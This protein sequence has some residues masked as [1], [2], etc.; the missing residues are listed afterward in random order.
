MFLKMKYIKT[1]ESFISESNKFE[2]FVANDNTYLKS[3]E[4]HMEIPEKE[5]DAILIGS[6][7]KLAKIYYLKPGIMV[8]KGD[9]VEQEFT[10]IE[11]LITWLN[12]NNWS[13]ITKDNNERSDN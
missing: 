4:A 3:G 6:R 9:D 10:N 7:E 1:F 13:Y 2:L 11:K 8:V 5:D 12:Q